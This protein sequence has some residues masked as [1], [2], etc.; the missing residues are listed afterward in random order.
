MTP[1]LSVQ[2]TAPEPCFPSRALNFNQQTQG[3]NSMKMIKNFL[4]DESGMETL[5]YAVIA[6]LVAAVAVA[7][8]A[9]GWGTALLTRL[10][11]ATT[12]G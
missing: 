3:A 6:G 5:E 11:R 1:S 2:T 9:T 4:N 10:N 8:Y 7:V 12:T